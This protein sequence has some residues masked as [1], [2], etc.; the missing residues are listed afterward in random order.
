MRELRAYAIEED[1]TLAAAYRVLHTF[2]ADHRGAHRGIEGLCVDDQGDI[3]ACAGWRQSGPGPLVYVFS[4][5]GAVIETHPAPCD[6]PMR[7]AFGEGES[8]YLSAADGHLYRTEA[9]GRRGAN[10]FSASRAAL[11]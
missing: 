2:G 6:L 7:V 11:V 4:P 3:I 10:R 1:G 9:I 8:L 5:S